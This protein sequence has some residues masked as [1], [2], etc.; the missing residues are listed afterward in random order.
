VTGLDVTAD[1]TLS[2][3]PWAHRCRPRK[4]AVV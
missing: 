2:R 3:S 1:A 4:S